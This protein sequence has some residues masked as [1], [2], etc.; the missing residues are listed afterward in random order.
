MLY[1]VITGTKTTLN[2]GM[3]EDVV[4]VKSIAGHTFVN[5]GAD[6]DKINIHSDS[7]TLEDML[8]LLTVSGDV[9]RADVLTLAKGFV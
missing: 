9:P 4:D 1:E 3:G 5:L 8:G 7:H 6:S 2:T